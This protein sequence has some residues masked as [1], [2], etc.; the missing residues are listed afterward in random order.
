MIKEDL[1][2]Y[3]REDK[4][5]FVVVVLVLAV[6]ILI[7]FTMGLMPQDA[8]YY[9][10]STFPD[11]S[12]FDHPPMVAYMLWLFTH[13]FGKSVF[14]IKLASLITSMVTAVVFYLFAKK[15][16]PRQRSRT[17]T[18]VLIVSV[19]FTILSMNATP[20]VPLMLFWTLSLL[21]LYKAIFIGGL[22]NWILAGFA[23]GLS[24]NSKY[25]AL[26]LPIGLILFL[27][28]S[29]EHRKKLISL[30]FV[31]A[32]VTYLVVISPVVYWNYSQNWIS[33][34]FQSTRRTSSIAEFKPHIEY[35]FGNIGTQMTLLS[36]VLF[37][38]ILS[39]GI[40]L[41]V[42]YLKKWKLPSG[43]QLFLFC[44]SL[45]I[46]GGFMFVSIF[47]WVK[48]N[49]MM[50]GYLSGIIFLGYALH[51]KAFKA[52]YYIVGV[53]NLLLLL[54]I[55]FYIVPVKSDDTWYGWDKLAAEID[56]IKVEYPD[57]FV[58]SSDD[59][60]TSAILNFYLTDTVYA[61]NVINE[62]A[63]QFNLTQGNLN[64]LQGK[65]AL[66]IDSDKRLKSKGRSEHIP[67]NLS[68]YFEEV[69]QLEPIVIT[70]RNKQVRK[71]FVYNCM[72]YKGKNATSQKAN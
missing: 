37:V 54:Q 16:L 7:P 45:P 24:F 2:S 22:L 39:V 1:K 43:K 28:L 8:Y 67:E 72:G 38:L 50:P 33:F 57:N 58:F 15:F 25:T 10:Y 32:I 5:A 21:F 61:G 31:V 30:P 66:F 40:I 52:H 18:L 53:L 68:N 17:I 42:G 14:S 59:Y 35:F 12:Y 19:L 48:L 70:K 63:L 44:F 41:I 46:L 69:V 64:H 13:V 56:D 3:F 11:L 65:D 26:L 34:T 9:Y 23:M 60:K 4:L 29:K 47:Y 20:D 71:W 27:I 36:P 49:W 6:R 51:K 62:K 55:V